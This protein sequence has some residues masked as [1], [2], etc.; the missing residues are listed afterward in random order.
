[1]NRNIP[2]SSTYEYKGFTIIRQMVGN[3][4]WNVVDPNGD[5]F[6]VGLSSLAESKYL[7]NESVYEDELTELMA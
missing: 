6:R 5:I 2:N 4:G 1:M 7:I 3:H